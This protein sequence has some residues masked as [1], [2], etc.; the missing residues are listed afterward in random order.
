M[1]TCHWKRKQQWNQSDWYRKQRQKGATLVV[2]LVILL[3]MSVIGISNMQSSTMQERMAAN[4]RQK[5]LA[6][7][8]A[9]SALKVAEGWLD[10]NVTSIHHLAQ[11]NGSS[12]L[13]S[14][15]M[16]S[17]SV[18]Q[19]LSTQDIADPT[20]ASQWGTVT[21]HTGGNIIDADLVSRQPQYIIEYIGRDYRGTAGKVIRT[22]DLSSMAE[23]THSKPLFFRITAIGWGK[24]GNIYTVLESIYKTG[25]AQYFNY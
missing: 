15:V 10:D 6:K 19:S 7:Y 23:S 2:A 1:A 18:A 21:A 14:A 3:I 17:Q 5:S 20:E 16:A 25:S 13:Y 11:F 9:E 22:D 8:S 12:G 24:D 4:S